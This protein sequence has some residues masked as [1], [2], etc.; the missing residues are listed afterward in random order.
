MFHRQPPT[1]VL[2][3]PVTIRY[4]S[5]LPRSSCAWSRDPTLRRHR[6]QPLQRHPHDGQGTTM[7]RRL[8]SW[9]ALTV[10]ATG[11]AATATN[12]PTVDDQTDVWFAQ[13]MVPHLL[14]DTSIASL[15]RDQLADPQLAQ[16]AD[17]IHRRSQAHAAKLVEW[18]AERGLAPHGHSHQQGDS[19]R[20]GDLERLSRL[21]GA[22]LD[23]A[24]VKVMTARD[25]TGAT[26]AVTEVRE[27]SLPEIRQ[28][29][30]QLLVEQ[31]AHILELQI[32]QRTW[33]KSQASRPPAKAPR[34]I[35]SAPLDRAAYDG[36]GVVG[37]ASVCAACRSCCSR[38]AAGM[39]RPR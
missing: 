10:L 4:P 20:R 23:L 31:E 11:C 22:A 32:W 34:L 3:V 24:F 17:R 36:S 19:L 25:R 12:Q 8:G 39:G 15:T 13:H 38:S 26:L 5:R 6:W 1:D 18:L 16:L 29:A 28:L 37:S 9:I 7:R 14:Q 2:G 30:R 27:G 35:E 21:N 33:S